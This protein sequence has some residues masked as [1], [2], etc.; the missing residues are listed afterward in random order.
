MFR[1]RSVAL[2]CV[3]NAA[4]IREK[5]FDNVWIQ[6]ASGDAG[7]ALGAALLAYHV[8]YNKERKISKQ[9]SMKGSFLIE[10]LMKMKLSRN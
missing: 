3:A 9:D 10:I 7:G 1:R 5:I 4:I 6:P 8:N 2:N